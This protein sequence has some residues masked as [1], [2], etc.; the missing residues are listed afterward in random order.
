MSSIKWMDGWILVTLTKLSILVT[1]L[2][3][4]FICANLAQKTEQ[5]R[6]Q[7]LVHILRKTACFWNL[8]KT[9]QLHRVNN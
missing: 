5:G 1:D 9:K 3:E 2:C 7:P 6:K 8:K 4:G